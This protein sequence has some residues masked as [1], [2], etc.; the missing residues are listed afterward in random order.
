MRN[1]IVR[2]IIAAILSIPGPAAAATVD[3]LEVSGSSLYNPGGMFLLLGGGNKYFLNDGTSWTSGAGSFKSTVSNIQS[4]ISSGNQ[5]KYTFI[6]P[7]DQIFYSYTDYNSGVHSSQGELGVAGPLLLEAEL[8]SSTAVMSGY[9]KI[10]SNDETWYGEPLFNHFSAGVGALVKYSLSY[11][12]NNATWT[13]SLFNNSFSYNFNGRIDFTSSKGDVDGDGAVNLRDVMIALKVLS[14]ISPPVA[15]YAASDVDGDNKI[16][17]AEAIYAL[18]NTA[19]LRNNHAPVLKAIGNQTVDEGKNLSFTVSAT[20]TDGDSLTYSV[21]ALPSGATFEAATKTFSWTPTYSQ[22][23]QYQVNFLVADGFGG[24][25]SEMITIMVNESLPVY[26]AMEY[27][28][29]KVGDWHDYYENTSGATVRTTI[30]DTKLIGSVTTMAQS[31]W[32]G[33]KEFYTSDQD[34]V[35]LYGQYDPEYNVEAIFDQ[36]L[37]IMPNIPAIGTPHFSTA[38]YSMV[39]SGDLLHVN[40]TST[41]DIMAIENVKTKNRELQDCIKISI[42]YDQVIVE[43]GQYVPGD[44]VYLWFYKGVGVV[45]QVTGSDIYTINASFIDGVLQNY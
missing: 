39:Y 20:D 19:R 45:K 30:A 6:P 13:E 34:G 37:L 3:L 44:T 28:P 40:I 12:L 18:Q 2:L 4:V 32:D 42:R 29:L 31:Y 25:A 17:L 14:G 22:G 15:V 35:K 38:H 16:G 33:T 1:V 9:V 23:G 41:T 11:T 8:G 27:Y 5:I 36:P 21:S 26:T 43:T 7:S 10:I 24:Q